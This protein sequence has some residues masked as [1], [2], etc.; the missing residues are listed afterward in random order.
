[1]GPS[2]L[3]AAPE[4]APNGL[5]FCAKTVLVIANCHSIGT[6]ARLQP[7][8]DTMRLDGVQNGAPKIRARGRPEED[9]LL[10]QAGSRPKQTQVTCG[11]RGP[12]W[13]GARSSSSG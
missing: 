5:F 7:I 3:A 13:R 10:L 9:G 1:M 8:V 11:R 12:V 4:P 2:A 6:A